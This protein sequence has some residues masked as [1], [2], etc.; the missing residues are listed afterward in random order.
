MQGARL[1]QDFRL[2]LRVQGPG[3]PRGIEDF[4]GSLEGIGFRCPLDW[5][6]LQPKARGTLEGPLLDEL[7]RGWETATAAGIHLS[8]S[9]H[10]GRLP[11]GL[12]RRG[13]WSEREAIGRFAE[14][15]A[16]L[17]RA[18]GDGATGFVLL[19]DPLASV[20]WDLLEASPLSPRAEDAFLRGTHIVNLALAE[21]TRAIRAERPELAIGR[22][23]RAA[24]CEPFGDGD[25]DAD[26]SDRFH[27]FAHHWFLQPAR[28]LRYPL[29]FASDLPKSRLDYR[30]EDGR[31]LEASIDFVELDVGPRLRIEAA[32]DE[33]GLEAVP[34]PA[35]EADACDP[36]LRAEALKAVA[37]RLADELP[38]IPLELTVRA[39]EPL[40]FSEW[41]PFH[42]TALSGACEAHDG[43]APLRSYQPWIPSE[44]S[45]SAPNEPGSEETPL[46]AL[47]WVIDTYQESR[48]GA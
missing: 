32:H 39:P 47:R 33:F 38:E 4:L 7:R 11:D 43:G 46:A 20:R 29:A 24:H 21:C 36:E 1:P 44:A 15:G 12:A 37:A 48:A 35:D 34:R 3:P 2:G 14:Y 23:I 13:G 27:A 28:D 16:A 40:P 5:A 19:E 17:A 10:T 6:A 22:H 9:L 42:R 25:S 41:R 8:F 45:H 31:H 18:L 26:A 30:E